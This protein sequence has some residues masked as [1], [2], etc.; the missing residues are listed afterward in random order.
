MNCFNCPNSSFGSSNTLSDI[1]DNCQNDV[2]NKST[3]VANNSFDRFL[4]NEQER[5]TFPI[6]LF[7]EYEEW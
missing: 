6:S 3:D 2:S 7:D 1:C 4:M 5:N